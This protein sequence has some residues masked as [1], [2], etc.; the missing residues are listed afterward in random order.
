MLRRREEFFK[1]NKSFSSYDFYVHTLAQESPSGG[2]AIYNSWSSL[3]HIQ[4]VCFMPKSREEQFKRNI[5]ILILLPQI[6]IPLRCGVMTFTISCPLTK[7]WCVTN[8]V[9]IGQ[10]VLED[11]TGRR[12]ADDRE[13]RTLTHINKSSA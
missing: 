6:Y 8:L 2:L 1:R 5:P 7:K 11:I 10:L 9:K 13:R 4:F 12:T 3:L